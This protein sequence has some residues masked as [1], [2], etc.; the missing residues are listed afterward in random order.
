[1]QN[2]KCISFPSSAVWLWILDDKKSREKNNWQFEK[3]WQF[4]TATNTMHGLQEELTNQSLKKLKLPT[5]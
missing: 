2:T 1:M 4:E 5:R 3:N